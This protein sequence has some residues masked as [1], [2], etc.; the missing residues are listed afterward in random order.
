MLFEYSLS[1]KWLEQLKQIA[2]NV[3]RAGVIRDPGIGSGSGQFA[4]IQTVAASLG[5]EVRAI[6]VRD[7]A[8]ME[9]AVAALAGSADA[10]LIVTA[11]P[12]SAV[13][14]DLIISLAARHKLPAL[15]FDRV[16]AHGGRINLVRPKF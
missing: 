9:R 5:L 16:F 10:G 12:L 13:H 7:P 4:V 11:S 6:D 1:G 14:R 2:P 3:K 8:G 15:Y